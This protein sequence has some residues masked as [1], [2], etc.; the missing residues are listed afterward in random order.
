[1]KK[2][3]KDMR[4]IFKKIARMLREEDTQDTLSNKIYV[5]PGDVRLWRV[6]LITENTVTLRETTTREKR[7]VKKTDLLQWVEV[8]AYPQEGQADA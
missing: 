3:V 2:V 6:T 7:V 5:L 4:A 8:K 1:V